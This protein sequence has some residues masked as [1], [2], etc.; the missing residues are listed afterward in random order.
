MLTEKN[1]NVNCKIGL[2]EFMI[3]I[4]WAFKRPFTD[5]KSL[6]IGMLINIF[7]LINIVAMGYSMSS[8][9]NATLKGKLPEWGHNFFE[10]VKNGLVCLLLSIGVFIVLFVFFVLSM[11]GDNGIFIIPGII[12]GIIALFFLPLELTSY[13]KRKGIGKSDLFHSALSKDYIISWIL[14]IIYT[15]V[16][17]LIVV[18]ISILVELATDKTMAGISIEILAGPLTF[19]GLLTGFA[20]FGQVKLK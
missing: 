17:L 13:V 15:I 14:W 19:I 6:I 20:M 4:I 11:M 7:P 3:D 10:Y 8:S 16:L 5:I 2:V 12:I 18:G 1:K 9:K